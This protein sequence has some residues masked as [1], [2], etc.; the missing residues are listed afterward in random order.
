[1]TDNSAAEQAAPPAQ[2]TPAGHA[3]PDGQS[4]P[5]EQSSPATPASNKPTRWYDSRRV[6]ITFMALFLA[7]TFLV[8]AKSVDVAEFTAA[9]RKMNPWWFLA[10][11]FAA[12]P[13]WL[14]AAI[15]I[16]VFSPPGSGVTV[17]GATLTQVASSFVGVATPAGLGPIALTVRYL[18]KC[19]L[20]TAQALTANILTQLVQFIVSLVV[21]VVALVFTGMSPNLKVPWGTV[22]LVAGAVLLAVALV[23][24]VPKWRAWIRTQVTT[25][26]SRVYP[27]AVWALHHPRQLTIALGGAAL[28]TLADVSSFLFAVLAF[29]T[30]VNWWKAAAIYLIFK[31]LGG[32]MPSPGGVGTVEASLAGGL[33]LIGVPA[34]EG[35]TIG[36]GYRLATFYAPIPLGFAAFRY[37]Q[38]K[39]MV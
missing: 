20:T 7:A 26:W 9:F 37:L 4:T 36:V 3:T 18:Q 6:R 39:Q 28:Q 22:G 11:F 35:V 31:T 1:M 33:R 13:A 38:R 14:G 29:G 32:L 8:V 19:G 15:P 16:V 5:G 24:L 30:H 12:M 25:L 21:V 10:A 23:M 2:A 27:E 17:R 34:A